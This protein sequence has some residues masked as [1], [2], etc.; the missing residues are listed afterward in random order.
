MSTVPLSAYLVLALIL[1]CIGLY[2]ALTK[3]NTV[4]VLICI[5]LMLNAVNINLVAFSK[6]G[7]NPS[8]T[9]QVFALF[10][11][12]VAAA[13]AAVGLAILMA[14]YRNRK[15]VHIDEMDSMK[16]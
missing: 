6:Y 5:E 15:T 16:H 13:E 9:G 4:I 12:T 1:F 11:I 8:I 10:T 3:R 2:G 7:V 14:L